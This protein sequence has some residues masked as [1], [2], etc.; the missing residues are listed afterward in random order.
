MV[1]RPERARNK[2]GRLPKERRRF[3]AHER[4]CCIGSCSTCKVLARARFAA[5]VTTLN[6]Y[7]L[8]PQSF[9]LYEPIPRI[10]TAPPIP[11]VLRR[12]FFTNDHLTRYATWNNLFLQLLKVRWLVDEERSKVGEKNKE[13]SIPNR[14][15]VCTFY[16]Y[17]G[18]QR[19][20]VRGWSSSSETRFIQ[21]RSLIGVELFSADKTTGVVA[22]APT[23]ART[24]TDRADARES[25]SR[26]GKRTS[27]RL[28]L[29]PFRVVLRK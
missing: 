3:E 10:F 8:E 4:R 17:S 11:R 14:Y 1:A 9:R 6:S 15:E 28:L 5:R 20:K 21:T 7:L 19:E 26:V 12:F 2:N 18:V 23:H 29:S 24:H 25:R 16:R 22:P 13:R 27:S